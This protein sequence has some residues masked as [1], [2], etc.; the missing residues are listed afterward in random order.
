MKVYAKTYDING[1][2]CIKQGLSVSKN[3]SREHRDIRLVCDKVG[4][5]KEIVKNIGK[6]LDENY[7]YDEVAYVEFTETDR[8]I[9]CEIDTW[10]NEDGTKGR[11]LGVLVYDYGF[12]DERK[13][14]IELFTSNDCIIITTN[15]NEYTLDKD[16][17]TF[18]FDNI[19]SY[20]EF[21]VYAEAVMTVVQRVRQYKE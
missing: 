19:N 10:E 21:R 9:D 7:E 5:I 4:N 15:P 13:K 1:I 2:T 12:Y 3:K 17:N 18:D 11:Y 14:E 20:K 16:Y 8:Y 6:E